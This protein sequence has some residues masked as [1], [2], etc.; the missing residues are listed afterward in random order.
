[1]PTT[2][3]D[4]C[5]ADG[6]V[7]RLEDE[8]IRDGDTSVSRRFRARRRHA[9]EVWTL[10]YSLLRTAELQSLRGVFE[11]VGFT[12]STLWTP[13]GEGSSRAF[14]FMEYSEMAIRPDAFDVKINLLALP[15]AS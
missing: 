5:F 13:P 15:G 11:A 2:L 7:R 6:F 10:L 1:M 14:R 12:G 9:R 8:T 4:F 3:D